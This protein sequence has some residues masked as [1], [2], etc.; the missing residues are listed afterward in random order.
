MYSTILV[1][2][3]GS[4]AAEDAARHALELGDRFGATVHALYVVD[5]R[6]SWMDSGSMPAIIDALEDTGTDATDSITAMAE[7]RDVPVITTVEHGAPSVRISDY[8]DK[9]GI[10]LI[11][12]GSQGKTGLERALIGSVT[13][14]TMRI[15]DSPILVVK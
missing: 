10:D 13:E 5:D 15:A 9:H 8:A 2:T 7:P 1:P 3:D 6:Y 14:K 12:M 4:D 11:V